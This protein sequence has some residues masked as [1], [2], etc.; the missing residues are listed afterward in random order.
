MSRTARNLRHDVSAGHGLADVLRPS[1]VR[2][3][4]SALARHILVF[5]VRAAP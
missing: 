3:G 2:L 4:H 5:A 1:R